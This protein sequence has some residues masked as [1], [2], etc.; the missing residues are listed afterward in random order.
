MSQFTDFAENKVADFFRGQTLTLPTS[1]YAA[2]GSAAS[3]ASFTEL[4]GTGYARIAILRS[5]ADWAGTQGDGTVLASTGS[6]HA[7]S[8]NGDVDWGTSGSAWGTANVVGLFDAS[9]SGNCWMWLELDSPIVIGSGDPVSI[10][11]GTLAWTLGLAGGMSD[12]ASNKMIDRIFRAQAFTWPATLYGAL[13]TAAPSNAGGGTEVNAVEYARQP[14]ASSLAAW[15]GTQA[16]A[17]T[18][19]STGTGGRISNN[20]QMVYPDP[21]TSWGG[22]THEGFYDALTLGNLYFWAALTTPRTIS[23]GGAAPLHAANTLGITVA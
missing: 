16:A 3:D 23:A 6:S 2:L 7:T 5:L 8:N 15:S 10:A 1:W 19:S 20:A 22:L 17:S 13:F 11:A 9:T 21:T 12:Y 14:I 4:T 18:T